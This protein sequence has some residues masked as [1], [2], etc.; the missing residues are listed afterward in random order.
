MKTAIRKSLSGM[1]LFALLSG[2][3]GPGTPYKVKSAK[4]QGL[5][6][7]VKPFNVSKHYPKANY[8]C[9]PLTGEPVYLGPNS[10]GALLYEQIAFPALI[11]EQLKSQPGVSECVVVTEDTPAVDAV[12]ET[13]IIASTPEGLQLK[14]S[15]KRMDGKVID[16]STLYRRATLQP[17]NLDPLD[18]FVF[19]I[20]YPLV[21]WPM[22]LVLEPIGEPIFCP[23]DPWNPRRMAW[24]YGN[25]SI[26]GEQPSHT[27]K[28]PSEIV[29]SDSKLVS[30]IAAEMAR[31]ARRYRFDS[32]E[33]RAAVYAENKSKQPNKRAVQ[34]AEEAGRV[35][36]EQLWAPLTLTLSRQVGATKAAY[37][38]WKEEALVISSK[39]VTAQHQKSSAE[40]MQFLGTMTSMAGGMSAGKAAA[41]GNVQLIAPSINVAA[42]GAVMSAQGDADL[43]VAENKIKEL[44]AAFTKCS[45]PFNSAA[46]R[47][48]TVR[49][50]NKVYYFKGS[51]EQML[52][53][54]HR[55][56]KEEITKQAS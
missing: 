19:G 7:G 40:A 9:A 11:A 39:K 30:M 48:M 3:A 21:I 44:N 23:S 56:V 25:N 29:D 18:I 22:R 16:S 1:L 43:K 32:K 38:A 12:V 8:H 50:Y 14:V 33:L 2:C 41:E 47:L 52:K 10:Q 35:E 36:R 28:S 45:E 46:G 37:Y 31:A 51:K 34:M 54:L 55:V 13:E 53:E 17:M 42:Q 6:I 15:L 49:I 24:P 5:I 26:Y 27:I 20:N 4:K